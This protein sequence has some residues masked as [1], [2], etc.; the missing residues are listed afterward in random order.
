M[1]TTEVLSSLRQLAGNF[2]WVWDRPTQELFRTLDPGA[3]DRYRNPFALLHDLPDDRLAQLAADRGYTERLRRART[4]LAAYLGDRPEPSTV[5]YFCMEHGIAAPLRVYAG[6]LGMLAGCIEKTASDLGVPMVAVGLAYRSWFRQRLEYGWQ[7]EDWQDSDLAGAGLE[8]CEPRVWVDLAGERAQVRVWRA[9]VGRVDLY[10]LD[11]DVPENPEHVRGITDR[12]YSG[13][14]EHRLRQEVVLGIAGVRALRALGIAPEVYHANEG[15]AGF[16]CL[17]RVRELVADGWAP[18]DARAAVRDGTVFTTHT[19]VP[20]GFDLFDRRLMNRYFTGFAA[21]CGMSL[22]E[23]MA[24]GHFPGQGGYEPFNMAVLCARLSRYVNA[25]SKLHREVT[26]DRVLG[27]LWPERAAPVRCVTNGVHPGTWTPPELAG[28]FDRHVGEG[29]EYAGP[30]AWQGVWDIPDELLWA[31]RQELRAQLV[32]W[33][34]DYLP[35]T[36]RA[37]GW[38]ADT[39]WA[40]RVLDPHA[41]TV[42]VARRAAEYKETDLLV[43]LPERLAALVH[44]SWRPVQVLIAGLAHPSDEGGKERIRRIVETSLHEDLRSRVVYLPG[45]DMRMAQALL[46][47]A[48][49]WL[50]HPRRGDEACGTSFMKS[51][52]SG[53]RNMTT[54]DGGADELIVDGDTG[55]II[56]DRRY[57]ASREQTAQRAFALLESVVVPEFYA[58]GRDGVPRAWVA[59]V[60]RS[61]AGLAWQVSSGRMVHGYARLYRDAQRAVRAPGGQRELAAA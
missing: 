15:H 18:A 61:M 4:G 54:A 20:A 9:R 7:H 55:W 30:D 27:P 52:Y 11:T 34:R 1:T 14:R 59:G 53:G 5:A 31:A 50:N 33:V 22:D 26:E 56:G 3:W 10:L 51:V 60:K 45:Y 24:L 48:D 36:L 6:G 47:G 29:W 41:L 49:V 42:V 44:D 58:R 12:L 46:T 13:D 25:V 23:L 43:S 17:E 35:R 19:A 16:M 38:T 57:G 2:R 28:L 21:D 39:A 37:G 40:T 8:L 32:A